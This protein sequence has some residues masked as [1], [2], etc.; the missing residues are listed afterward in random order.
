MN[1]FLEHM[2]VHWIQA[3]AQTLE[4]HMVANVCLVMM[5]MEEHVLIS[6]NVRCRQHMTATLTRCVKA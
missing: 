3:F 5:A 4:V 1:V 6:T 2:I